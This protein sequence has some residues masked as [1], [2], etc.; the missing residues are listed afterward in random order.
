[1]RKERVKGKLP[2]ECS[3]CKTVVFRYASQATGNIFCSNACIALKKKNGIVFNCQ[4]CD[5]E[6]YRGGG[7]LRGQETNFCSIKC[8]QKDRRAKAKKTT[9]LKTGTKHSH[10]V[11]AEEILKRKLKKNEVVHHIDE[12]KHN[13]NPDNL[14][15]LPSQSFHA[16]VHFSKEEINIDKYLLKNLSK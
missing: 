7:D 12:N 13:N 5:K 11:V 3:H 16:K 1:M 2:Y 10:I 8:Y 4:K 9:Y 15:I 14:A 6:F